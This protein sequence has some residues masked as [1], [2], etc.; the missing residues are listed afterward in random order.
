MKQIVLTD[1]PIIS[2]RTVIENP[3]MTQMFASSLSEAENKTKEYLM[4]MYRSPDYV[5]EVK[6][7][8]GTED[9]RRRIH[10]TEYGIGFFAKYIICQ[11]K[12]KLKDK[13]HGG[14]KK[15]IYIGKRGGKYYIKNGKK[16]YV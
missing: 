15:K 14:S 9:N 3:T 8:W 11:Y 5:A 2:E 10:V 13:H 12:W 1:Q 4:N 16:I 7:T 6:A